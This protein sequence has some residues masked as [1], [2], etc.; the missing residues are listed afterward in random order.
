MLHDRN[1]SGRRLR[2]SNHD[3]VSPSITPLKRRIS[4]RTLT[5]GF[6]SERFPPFSYPSISADR[7]FVPA[8]YYSRAQFVS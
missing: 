1:H 8:Q 2:N 6:I 5:K 3:V 4:M 7:R